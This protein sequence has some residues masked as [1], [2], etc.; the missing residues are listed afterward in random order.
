VACAIYDCDTVVCA[1]TVVS[2]AIVACNIVTIAVLVL[3][4]ALCAVVFWV[5]RELST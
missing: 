3:A 5:A 4:D 1:A 2:V